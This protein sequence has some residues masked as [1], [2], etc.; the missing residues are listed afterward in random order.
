MAGKSPNE[1]EKWMERSSN[2]SNYCWGIF[3]QA[4]CAEGKG[5][6]KIYALHGHGYRTKIKD[7]IQIDQAVWDTHKTWYIK[8]HKI[9]YSWP[10]N[11]GFP[12]AESLKIGQ[13]IAAGAPRICGRFVLEHPFTQRA[14]QG[15]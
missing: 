6:W 9:R 13:I 3:Q 12:I 2:Y 14:D 1:M 5:I 11:Q 10:G 8:Y 7:S 4:M 15:Y